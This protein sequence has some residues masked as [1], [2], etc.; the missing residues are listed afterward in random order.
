MRKVCEMRNFWEIGPGTGDLSS[1]LHLN[2]I[3]N[4]VTQLQNTGLVK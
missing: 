2:N 3:T 4:K 1:V